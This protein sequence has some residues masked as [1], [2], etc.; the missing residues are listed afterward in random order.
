[1]KK[2]ISKSNLQ[3]SDIDYFEVNEAFSVTPLLTQSTLNIP[4]EK[5]NVNGGAVSLGHPVGMSGARILL[6][7]INTL[8]TRGGNYGCVGICNGGGGATSVVI[9]KIE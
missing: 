5:I 3:V 2:A 8:R 6:S 9:K 1:M 4:L 7:M